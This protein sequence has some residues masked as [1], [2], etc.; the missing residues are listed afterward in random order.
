MKKYTLYYKDKS[1][2]RIALYQYND[3]NLAVSAFERAME[4]DNLCEEQGEEKEF[5]LICNI[6]E[7]VLF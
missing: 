4:L 3:Y 5:H 6:D 2:N 7:T 1:G